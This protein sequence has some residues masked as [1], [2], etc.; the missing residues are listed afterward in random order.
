MDFL[1]RTVNRDTM[2]ADHDEGTQRF[3]VE[4]LPRPLK[5]ARVD[6]GCHILPG[7]GS[8]QPPSI[9]NRLRWL[10]SS[11]NAFPELDDLAG[12]IGPRVLFHD[13]LLATVGEDDDRN[14][15]WSR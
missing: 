1:A 6:R 14:S 15:G 12:W 8:A 5:L 10:R 3:A 7:E 2:I 13:I 9:C 11:G 4:R